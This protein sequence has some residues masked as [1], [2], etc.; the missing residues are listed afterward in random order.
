ME[1]R[2][3]HARLTPPATDSRVILRIIVKL[4]HSIWVV[5]VTNSGLHQSSFELLSPG[6]CDRPSVGSSLSPENAQQRVFLSFLNLHVVPNNSTHHGYI[7][8]IKRELEIWRSI[9]WMNPWWRNMNLCLII[10]YCFHLCSCC[11]NPKVKLLK[12]G[13]SKLHCKFAIHERTV[14]FWFRMLRLYICSFLFRYEV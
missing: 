6:H 3:S 1:W 7:W 2:S 9:W 13:N 4:Q 10:C 12:N 11:N 14:F 8:Q 5:I